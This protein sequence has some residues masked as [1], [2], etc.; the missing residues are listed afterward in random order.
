[1]S[2]FTRFYL[3]TSNKILILK[4]CILRTNNVM[5]FIFEYGIYEPS[6]LTTDIYNGMILIIRDLWPFHNLVHFTQFSEMSFL[7]GCNKESIQCRRLVFLCRHSSI[8]V[9]LVL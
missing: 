1:M 2:L 9:L 5:G 4:G 8:W 6:T 3:A 7:K